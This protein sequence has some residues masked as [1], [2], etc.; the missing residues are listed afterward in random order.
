[1]DATTIKTAIGIIHTSAHPFTPD[2]SVHLVIRPEQIS[3]T[4]AMTDDNLF[5]IH[6]ILAQRFL[7]AT[8][9]YQVQIGSLIMDLEIAHLTSPL[10]HISIP[11]A[12]IHVLNGASS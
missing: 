3:A 10:T 9:A 12:S 5:S 6:T 7:G 4:P 2:T 8:T 1:M 11:K